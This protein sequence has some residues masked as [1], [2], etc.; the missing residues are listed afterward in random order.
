MGLTRTFLGGAKLAELTPLSTSIQS[1]YSWSREDRLFV[2]RRYQRKLVW[3]LEEKQKLVD[4]ILRK[5]PIP[6]ILLAEKTDK[7]NSYERIDGL[8]RLHAIVSFIEMSFP[9]TEGSYFN[10]EYFPTAKAQTDVGKF[11]ARSDASLISQSEVS[12]ILDYALP[13]LSCV[14]PR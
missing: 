7:P 4:F 5:F 13:Y 8:Q 10:L 3:T 12:T 11:T 14:T 9:T 2:N 1:I 6:A